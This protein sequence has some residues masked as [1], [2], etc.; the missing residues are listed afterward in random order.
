MKQLSNYLLLALLIFCASESYAQTYVVGGTHK[1]LSSRSKAPRRVASATDG[2]ASA[3]STANCIDFYAGGANYSLYSTTDKTV[4][5]PNA[6]GWEFYKSKLMLDVMRNNST[7]TY[8]ISDDLYLD[9]GDNMSGA[10]CVAVD[11]ESSKIF[12]FCISKTPNVNYGM[13]GYVF[14]A[15]LDDFK[16][17]R[18]TVFEESNW[19]WFSYFAYENSVLSVQHFSYAGYFSMM[20]TFDGT[21]WTTTEGSYIRP[22]VFHEEADQIGKLLVIRDYSA[23][24]SYRDFGDVNGDTKVDISDI[25][26]V[27]NTIA[28]STE[29]LNPHADVNGDGGI[30]ISDI[31]M[32]INVIAMA[33]PDR[34]IHVFSVD[35]A[36]EATVSEISS[37]GSVVLDASTVTNVPDVGEII[38]SGV[39]DIA[40]RGFLCRV[41]SVEQSGGK[42]VMRTSEATL[43]EVLPENVHIEESLVFRE[44]GSGDY[45]K[46]M[47]AAN[48]ND[49]PKR[50]RDIAPLH[51]KKDF[52]F[53]DKFGDKFSM[54][55]FS[56]DSNGKVVSSESSYE[57]YV[58]GVVSVDFSM[59]GK[60]IYDSGRGLIPDRCGIS[61]DG[62]LSVGATVEAGIKTMYEKKFGSTDLQPIT[63]V[64]FGVPIVICP[65]IQ[66]KYGVK[67]NGKIYAKWKPIDIKAATFEAHLIWNKEPNI[68]GEN[69][70]YDAS[71]SLVKP[72]WSWKGFLN[73]LPEYLEKAMNLEV[74]MT[75]D[76][77]LSIWPEVRWKLYNAENISLAVGISPYAK[78]SGELALKWQADKYSWEDVE[79]KDNL[80]LSVGVDIPLKGKL[81]FK[82]FGKKIGGE[83]ETDIN[84]LDY[85]LV[86]GASLMPAF[87][88]FDVYPKNNAKERETVSLT[89]HKSTSIMALLANN[90]TDFGF[91]IAEV[92]KDAATGKTGAW[93]WEFISLKSQYNDTTYGMDGRF[94]MEYQLPSADLKPD[95]TYEVRPYTRL[96]FGSKTYTFK[97]KGGT[98]KTGGTPGDGGAV[99]VDIP[100]ENF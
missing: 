20:S 37:D 31:V 10:P 13:A 67:T 56:L 89:V 42:V 52:E 77:K 15:S 4:V 68:Y 33:G 29:S 55:Y 100:G 88:D 3:V 81:E 95:A 24:T 21:A 98:F 23:K 34:E 54:K 12:V 27:I 83:K 39:T 44:A 58:K 82:A 2:N 96:K 28:G 14:T 11:L 46:D 50:T 70:D 87:F 45:V 53:Y 61:L 22:E 18:E 74:G 41:E 26:A 76:A 64:V 30:D 94:K 73:S 71:S 48:R 19:G 80:S 57:E 7:T 60:F 35:P 1:P 38:V 86:E 6:D 75:G 49:G 69:W 5:H 40:P 32:V 47:Q 17:Q 84:L 16:F 43:N 9:D 92:E 59:G 91:C 63:F 25:V 62:T 79:L 72:D 78:L 65:E 99:I 51:L 66:Y 90:E 8:L 36:S 97:R 85:P 93:D